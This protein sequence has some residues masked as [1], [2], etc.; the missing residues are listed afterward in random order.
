[1]NSFTRTHFGRGELIIYSRNGMVDDGV[2]QYYASGDEYTP[3]A[4]A[5]AEAALQ[6]LEAVV[7]HLRKITAEGP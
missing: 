6:E 2:V 1:M 7:D 3:V 4:W 5:D